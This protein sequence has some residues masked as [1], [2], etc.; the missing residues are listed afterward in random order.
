M[1]KE[2]RYWAAMVFMA[3]SITAPG[4]N[5]KVL[6]YTETSGFDHQ[7]R[8]NSLAMFR[9]LGN[10]YGFAVDDDQTGA[11][12]DT[13]ANLSQYAVVIFSNTSG[14]QILD[15]IQR[16]NFEAYLQ[17]GGSLIGIH[18]ASDTYRHSSA[19]GTKTGS[20]DWYAEALDASVQQNPN[21]T[22]ANF[23]GTLDKVGNHPTTV[24][25]PN[26]WP[27]TEEY[28]YWEKG[29]LNSNSNTV[30][31]V[32]STGNQSYDQRR[33]MSWTRTLWG[34]GR[35]FYKALGHANSNFTSDTAFQNHLR[36]A[37]L[38]AAKNP[39]TTEENPVTQK[40]A[41]FPNPV[42]RQLQV[43]LS[44][45]REKLEYKIRDTAGKMVLE[46]SCAVHSAKARIDVAA[47][48]PGQYF[49]RFKAREGMAAYEYAFSK[50]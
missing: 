16:A 34:G 39:V 5:F 42:Q 44:A 2:L 29:Y 47:L 8:S 23:N 3:F 26:P 36:E 41:L 9:S 4:Q 30:L 18:A 45:S 31:E 49:I 40:M 48:A 32:R 17:N 1:Q 35:V 13:L 20:W 28:Y 24:A 50:E 7:T 19:N 6:H 33:P 46:G 37:V 12:F 25:V 38:W 10:Q 11:S 27:K 43:E 15:S 21:H 14:E 22:A